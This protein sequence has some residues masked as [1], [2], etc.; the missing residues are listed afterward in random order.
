M[1]ALYGHFAGPAALGRKRT[2]GATNDYGRSEYNESAEREGAGLKNSLILNPFSLFSR[3]EFP[4]LNLR[5]F[6]RSARD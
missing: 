4:V 1:G 2:R 3:A 5:Q 6:M